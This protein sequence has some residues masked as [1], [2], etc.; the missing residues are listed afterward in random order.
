MKRETLNELGLSKEQIDAVMGEHG[1]SVNDLKDRLA[2]AESE[3]N[4]F[5]DQFETHQS[6]IEKQYTDK[7]KDFAIQ[8]AMKSSNAMDNDIVLGL[9]DRE[10]IAINGNE[11]TGLD[12]QLKTLKESK[13]FLFEPT[14]EQ[15]APTPR[16]V[17]GGNPSS[18]S[19]TEKDAFSSIT[20]KYQ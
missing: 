19:F 9:L 14:K 12:E 15:L 5:K 7:Q 2:T 16:I 17:V 6:E 3:R 13:P 18:P 10:Q 8:Y 4:Q 11:L 20:D 1:K